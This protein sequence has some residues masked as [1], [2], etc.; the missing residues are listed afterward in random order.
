MPELASISKEHVITLPNT[1][2][3]LLEHFI[4]F[5]S[6]CL[7]NNLDVPL[8]KELHYP[9]SRTRYSQNLLVVYRAVSCLTDDRRRS[10]HVPTLSLQ[11]CNMPIGAVPSFVPTV[12]PTL[13]QIQV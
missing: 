1:E 5:L 3:P 13:L 6:V 2:L 7:F 8:L 12:P 9:F 11:I 10:Y 4:L